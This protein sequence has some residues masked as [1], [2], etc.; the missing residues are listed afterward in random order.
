MQYF[1]FPI[2]SPL[3]IRKFIKRYS[4]YMYNYICFCHIKRWA[5]CNVRG[6][7]DKLYS[8]VHS[9]ACS[10]VMNLISI[11]DYIYTPN[12]NFQVVIPVWIMQC[13]I[14]NI[15]A[16]LHKNLHVWK[17]WIIFSLSYKILGLW[18]EF[19]LHETL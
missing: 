18:I 19:F 11:Y 12:T 9:K 13:I 16:Y 1:S 3:Y 15:Q 8:C 17:Y 4:I 6:T 10:L 14:K 2:S 5:K 7:Y